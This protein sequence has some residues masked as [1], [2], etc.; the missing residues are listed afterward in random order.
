MKKR[1]GIFGGSFD[2]VHCGH[3]RIAN[4]FLKSGLI[5]ELLVLLSPYPPHKQD[6]NQT[7]F[8]HRLAMLR[9]AFEDMENV[10]ISDL[11]HKLPKPSYTLQTIDHLQS[12]N[13]DTLFYLCLGQDSLKD[14]H[15]WHKYNEILEKVELLV[16]ERPDVDHSEVDTRI[17]EHTI[18]VDHKLYQVSSTKIRHSSG[19]KEADLPNSVAHYIKENN[20]YQ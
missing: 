19:E 9:L 6:Q 20:L 5:G 17:L 12:S 1:V 14:F 15:K 18:F 2:P 10:T 7:E 16:A 3:V 8:S 4:S 13:P 11:E